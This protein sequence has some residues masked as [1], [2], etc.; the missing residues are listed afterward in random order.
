VYQIAI[1]Y[2]VDK[3]KWMTKE[4]EAEII[5]QMFRSSAGNNITII[6]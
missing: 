6:L 3:E 4:K 2:F 5:L 1:I